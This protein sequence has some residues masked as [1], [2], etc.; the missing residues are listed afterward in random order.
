VSISVADAVAT[1]TVD[2][3]RVNAMSDAV[4]EGLTSA[5]EAVSKRAD[6]SAC[7]LAG[8]GRRAFMAGADLDELEG[9]LGDAPALERHVG[10]TGWMLE[11]W[12]AVPQPV[13][14]AVQAHAVGGGLEVALA[15]D[16][17]VADER[18]R[19]GFPELGLGLIPGAGGTQ[20]L[21]ARI[22]LAA[23]TRLILTAE[24]VDARE[25]RDIGLV[26]VVVEHGSAVSVATE[27]ARRIAG[28]ARTAV[29]AATAAL[30]ASRTRELD[31]GLSEERR[32]FLAQCMTRDARDG[33]RR[34]HERG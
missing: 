13:I 16:L 21:P 4:L 31:R 6:V 11:A 18:A 22:G 28:Q 19:L 12:A 26:D 10:L 23:A 14:A 33:V 32:L 20:R 17:I 25:G 30:R 27:L 29:L 9:W 3:P 15:C 1:V 34:F 8:A 7:V 24:L 5:A 2:Q